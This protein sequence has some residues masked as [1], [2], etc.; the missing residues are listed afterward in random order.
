MPTYLKIIRYEND[1][2]KQPERTQHS[3]SIAVQYLIEIKIHTIK[4]K[5]STQ[6]NWWLT[7][8]ITNLICYS[9]ISSNQP[10]DLLQHY[11]ILP[12]IPQR[13]LLHIYFLPGGP[14]VTKKSVLTMGLKKC[15]QQALFDQ[16]VLWSLKINWLAAKTQ[17][18]TRW[19]TNLIICNSG[20]AK[21]K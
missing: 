2:V 6:E 15:C 4:A 3:L 8:K 1:S 7:T 10:H 5:A 21:K 19:P 17:E 11:F 16:L 20:W 12:E 9:P 13:S 18:L 14:C